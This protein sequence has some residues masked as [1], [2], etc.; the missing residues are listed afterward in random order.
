MPTGRQSTET[1]TEMFTKKCPEMLRSQFLPPSKTPTGMLS[2]NKLGQVSQEVDTGCT[3][4][5]NL[6]K[7]WC[8]L[9]AHWSR[10]PMMIYAS[11]CIY[12]SMLFANDYQLQDILYRACRSTAQS[13]DCAGVVEFGRC[14][15]CWET[16][17][18]RYQ[19]IR[20]GWHIWLTATMY[21][22]S[23]SSHRCKIMSGR[24]PTLMIPT[25][26]YAEIKER[27]V[28]MAGGAWVKTLWYGGW[29]H[30]WMICCVSLL[31]ISSSSS[32]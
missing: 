24:S 22:C 13:S 7:L 10:L 14:N 3:Q 11:H 18:V 12:E 16:Y 6:E 5:A 23:G 27:C 29:D 26:T 25:I 28:W 9:D 15:Y 2:M 30:F 19:R 31:F 20:Y 8:W 32:A 1:H 17:I 21:A 4:T